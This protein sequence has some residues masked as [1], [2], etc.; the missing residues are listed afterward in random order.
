[1]SSLTS[2]IERQTH[3]LV[4]TRTDLEKAADKL[5]DSEQRSNLAKQE[6]KINGDISL[7]QQDQ[8]RHAKAH[9]EQ[10]DHNLNDIREKLADSQLSQHKLQTMNDSLRAGK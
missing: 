4:K 6:S 8:L 5:R 1:M 9:N 10:L 2:T 3:E 7:A